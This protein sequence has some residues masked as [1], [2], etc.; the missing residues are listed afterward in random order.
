[1]SISKKYKRPA[2]LPNLLFRVAKSAGAP[3]AHKQVAYLWAKSLGGDSA[4][5]LLSKFGLLEAAI[6]Y[7]SENG[8][9][10]FA[11]DLAKT[12]MESKMPDIH[13]KYAMSL[14]DNGNFA[15]AAAEF[16]KA[17]KPKEAVLMYVH[18]Q[19]WENAQRVAQNHDPDSVNEV[20]IGQAKLSFE[21]GSYQRAEAY[22]LRAQRA[23]LAVKYY[24]DAK[25]WQDALRVAKE[26]A[27]SKLNSLQAEYDRALKSEGPSGAEGMYKQA[28]DWEAQG[29]YTQAIA[30]YCKITSEMTSDVR[31]LDKS[32]SKAAELA[33]KFLSQD[34]ATRVVDMVAPRL[35][36]IQKHSKAAELYIN[37]D[38]VRAAVD[39]LVRGRDYVKAKRVAKEFAPDLEAYV[40]EQYK[41]HLKHE[42]D[43]KTMASV[44]VET[45][46]DMY[47]DRGQWQK[48]VE[49]AEKVGFKVRD[50]N[51]RGWAQ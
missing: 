5:K 22:L 25:M 11:F 31:L 33:L 40:D 26:F 35:I 18:I 44:D 30:C 4:V 32:W 39:A 8:S 46:L 13:L 27:P 50:G 10:D 20:L 47:V 45:A 49:T 34:K 38:S 24:R 14:E 3:T 16:V 17:Q 48:C 1:M 43:T 7:A 28:S 21:E 12:G 6:D 19:D 51:R 29:E 37:V 2:Y 41:D 42:G 23:D 36:E 9:Y 15:E